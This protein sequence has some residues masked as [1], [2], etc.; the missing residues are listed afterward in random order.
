MSDE[1]HMD[2]NIYGEILTSLKGYRKMSVSSE[3][4]TGP[5]FF[6]IHSVSEWDT[7][8]YSLNCNGKYQVF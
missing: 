3:F 6:S 5:S 7:T 2:Y 8:T 1:L 4:T